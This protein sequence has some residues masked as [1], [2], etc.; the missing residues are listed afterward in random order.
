MFPPGSVTTSFVSNL[1]PAAVP[2]APVYRAGSLTYTKGALLTLSF[3]LLWG[4]FAFAFFESIFTKFLPLFL[5]DLHASNTLVG[6]M[7]GGIV[8]IVNVLCLPG[9]S[10]WSDG[11]RSPF[12]RRIPFL[13]V[14]TPITVLSLILSGFSPE[15]ARFLHTLAPA[16]I[17]SVLTENSLTLGL[18]CLFVVS[19]D[20]FNMILVCA[21]NWLLR[22]VVPDRVM[23]RFLSCFRI[24]NTI[25]S[26]IFL[27]FVFPYV[28]SHRAAV[29]LSVGIFYFA[30]FLIMCIKVK[31]GSYPERTAA[32]RTTT[33]VARSFLLF[34][35]ECLGHP[36]YR[37]YIVVSICWY[38]VSTCTSPFVTLLMNETLH[39]DMGDMG[40]LFAINAAASALILYPLGWACDRFGPLPVTIGTLAVQAAVSVGS[41][42]LVTDKIS[43]TVYL[44]LSAFPVVSWKLASFAVSVKIFPQSSF[45]QFASAL[46][47]F[48]TGAMVVGNMLIGFLIDITH[49]EYRIAF[50]WAGFFSLAALAAMLMVL[51]WYDR[52]GGPSGYQAPDPTGAATP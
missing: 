21:Y 10:R 16:W 18:L 51:N 19:Y 4:D 37:A 2:S 20:F 3:W 49:N 45:A 52:L 27:K 42:F 43:M 50:A 23:A 25:G 17:S 46:N 30:A 26:M 9:I 47:V 6:L 36:I 5:R 40:T 31:E 48:G 22:D 12:G 7:T 28:L 13:L 38:L 41:Y 11:Y 14:S 15:I 44:V 1:H 8:G 32:S 29:F 34:F 33:G 39:L 24:V 35:R